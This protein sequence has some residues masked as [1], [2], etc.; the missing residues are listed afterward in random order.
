MIVR[1]ILDMLEK[2]GQKAF[3][4]EQSSPLMLGQPNILW[5]CVLSCAR[6]S[7]SFPCTERRS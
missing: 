5:R 7:A 1:K 4:I 2:G 6:L 3:G